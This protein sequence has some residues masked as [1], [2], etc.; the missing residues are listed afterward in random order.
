MKMT[1]IVAITIMG[2]NIHGIDGGG[3]GDSDTYENVPT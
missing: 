3:D 2:V 1:A